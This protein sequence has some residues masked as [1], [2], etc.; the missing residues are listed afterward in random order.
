[1]LL[2]VGVVTKPF[3]FE[4]ARRGAQADQG[5]EDLA[6]E[7]EVVGAAVGAVIE[8]R[9]R[10]LGR[11]GVADR[12]ADD[13]VEDLLAEPLAQ[14]RSC[15]TRVTG[16]Q[17]GD[18][19]RMILGQGMLLI[20]AGIVVGLVASFAL[21][22]LMTSLLFGVKAVDPLTFVADVGTSGTGGGVIIPTNDGGMV[23]SP[24]DAPDAPPDF[25]TS[26]TSSMCMPRSTALHMS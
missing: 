5:V 8:D 7:V 12:L 9:D 3:A 2:T 21:T 1:M 20:I 18:V 24:C 19:L 15:F 6:R 16:A 14:L 25:A 23:E 4:G 22:R 10:A 17:V 26:R 11:L 13:A